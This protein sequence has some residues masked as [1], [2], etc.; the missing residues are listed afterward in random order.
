MNHDPLAF[1]C[2]IS[3]PRPSAADKR[4]DADRI[5]DE[6][7]KKGFRNV[8]IPLNVMR[9]VP[10]KLR[11]HNF[12]LSLV[13]GYCHDGM[14][15]LAVGKARVCGLA[16][17]IG[18]TNMV[19]TMMDLVSGKKV[20]M[21]E[22]QNPQIAFGS[23]I[24]ERVQRS[25][26][27]QDPVLSEELLRGL[28][29]MIGDLCRNC[30]IP[31]EDIFAVTVAGNT[32]M[33]HFFLGLDVRNIS[34]SPFIP[35]ISTMAPVSAEET[36]LAVNRNAVVYVFPN[37][38]SYV[39][40]DIISGIFFSG[41][42]TETEP[43]LFVDVGTNVEMVLG[44][45]D[46]IMV[47]AGA[48]GPALEEGVANIGKKAEK[49]IIT[50]V[51]IDPVTQDIELNVYDDSKPQG[52]CGSGMIDLIAE[53]YAARII[54][55]AGKFMNSG[56][57]VITKEGQRNYV[58][59]RDSSGEL[60]ISENEIQ[61][62]LRSKAAMFAFLFVFVR[63]V[64]LMPRDIRKIYIA[65]ALG[66]GINLEK[67]IAI[68]LLPDLPRERFVPLGNASIAGAEK[69]LYDK[70]NIREIDTIRTMITYREMGEDSDLLTVLQGA[71]FIPHTDPE[72][73]KG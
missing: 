11:E 25:M 57:G 64:G 30:G 59:Y 23:D 54:D 38:G 14:R 41:L 69:V 24:L 62:F 65:G 40:G 67:A 17:D 3:L 15:V 33:N 43:V 1:L 47:G 31:A 49:G 2:R 34:V 9:T 22:R 52:I 13:L 70:N 29:G 32:V 19:C 73:L 53:L 58:V 46:W 16:F 35:A 4:P 51:K 60:L 21:L 68:G 66:C 20:A 71:L 42:H 44:C 36:G 50:G 55:Q 18:T 61:N 56:Q 5:V 72:I 12:E 7:A 8:S 45:R 39:G 27:G 63:S 37:A 48:A 6:L 10:E 26:M 28:N